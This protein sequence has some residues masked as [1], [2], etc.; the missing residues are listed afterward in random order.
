MINLQHVITKRTLD[1]KLVGFHI[2]LYLCD[3]AKSF[4]FITYRN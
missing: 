1:E 4:N 2:H 3:S